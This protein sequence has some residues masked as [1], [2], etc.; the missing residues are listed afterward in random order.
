MTNIQNEEIKDEPPETMSEAW[1]ETCIKKF[2][3]LPV[4]NLTREIIQKDAR[5]LLE[6]VC[7]L[8]PRTIIVEDTIE[9]VDLSS[10]A[11]IRK[12]KY[13]ISAALPQDVYLC[14]RDGRL[15]TF[16]AHAFNPNELNAWNALPSAQKNRFFKIF[17]NLVLLKA[18]PFQID[19]GNSPSRIMIESDIS[20]SNWGL[21][22]SSLYKQL[23]RLGS[24][25]TYLLM[26]LYSILNLLPMKI[27]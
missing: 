9:R 7:D 27:D 26:K 17:Y 11:Y 12:Y 19:L 24:Y 14:I 5:A 16:W 8:K 15:N 23:L 25:G 2:N 18:L 13:D 4:G 21:S 20:I 3:K 6:I 22:V 1:N 10:Y